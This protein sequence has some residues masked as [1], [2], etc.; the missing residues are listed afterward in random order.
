M[1]VGVGV[2]TGVGLGLGVPVS[3]PLTFS[4]FAGDRVA[5]NGVNG[6]G[7][8]SVLLSILGK[9]G[10]SGFLERPPQLKISYVGQDVSS[11]S[12][13]LADY[14]DDSGADRALFF[15]VLARLGFSGGDF[16][17]DLSEMSEGQ[18]KKAALAR[19]LSERAHLYV[20][21]EPLNFVDV[22]SRVQ[23]ENLL[24]DF[25]PSLLFVEHDGAFRKNVAT[26]VV[27]L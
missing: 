24:L 7:K 8:S 26:S 3:P 19:S 13:S 6:S 10:Y 15:A 27:E 18:K 14:A 9:E 23:I 22:L 16:F 25:C 21:D 11:L 5:L 4:V 1:G 20:W 17:A 12:G 2:G